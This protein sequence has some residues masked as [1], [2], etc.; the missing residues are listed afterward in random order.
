VARTTGE[1]TKPSHKSVS[2]SQEADQDHADEDEQNPGAVRVA[3]INSVDS[4]AVTEV[5]LAMERDDSTWSHGENESRVPTAR[6]NASQ[7]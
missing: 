1:V 7:S 3:G 6:R 5:D 2:P 4:P